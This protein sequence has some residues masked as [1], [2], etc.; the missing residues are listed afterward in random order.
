MSGSNPTTAA[1]FQGIPQSISA[2]LAANGTMNDAWYRF[3][4]TLWLQIS[5]G[6]PNSVTLQ[7]VSAAAAAAQTA[8]DNAQ[9]AANAAQ[10]TANQAISDIAAETARAEAAEA[11]L[12]AQLDN[13]NAALTGL[14]GQ[15]NV[16][17]QRLAN[18][19]IP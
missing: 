8:A 5:S 16:I 14:Q 9:A 15:I 6:T 12:Q 19:G 11:N 7:G 13:V 10:G 2:V 1:Q 4:Q 18:A 3:F 17:N